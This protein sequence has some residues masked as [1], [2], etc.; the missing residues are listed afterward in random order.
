MDTRQTPS[1]P[2]GPPGGPGGI[3]RSGAGPAAASGLA[4]AS[5]PAGA[6][7]AGRSQDRLHPGGYELL[8]P[9]RTG[10]LRRFVVA[11][12][13]SHWL[14][15]LLFIVAFVTG[16]LMW[17][18]DTRIWLAGTR[19]TVSQFHGY[20]GAAMV[21]LPLLLF[22]V[23]DRRR[24]RRDIQEIDRWDRSDRRWFWLA[25]RGYTLRGREMPPQGRFNAGQKMN[26]VLVAAMALGFAATGGVLMHRADVPPWLVSRALW[27]HG[28]LAVVAIALFAGHLAHVFL[29]RHGRTYLAAMVRGWIPDTLARERH[30]RWWRAETAQ[31]PGVADA[32]AGG[33]PTVDPAGGGPAADTGDGG[34]GPG[35]DARV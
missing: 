16:L 30:E 1:S 3:P 27:L 34:A 29:T 13:L 23:I 35:G 25:L 15:A 24:L 20:V 9:V 26:V 28:V 17:I 6:A 14:Y 12:R 2:D 32:A 10:W 8:A 18:P 31:T 22:L 19:Y 4:A 7:P 11:E 21:V 33:G 5:R